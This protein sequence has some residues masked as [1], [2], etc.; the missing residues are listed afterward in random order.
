M[1]LLVLYQARDSIK[2]HPGYHDG[3]CRL[4]AEGA[5]ESHRAIPYYSVSE[6]QGW[7]D[8]WEEA[9]Q[10]ARELPADAVFLQFFHARMPNPSSG[11]LRIKELPLHMDGGTCRR[12]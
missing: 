3:F 12:G 6:K 2:G 11:I 4:V 8:L 7:N 9:Y 1:K 5:L 10:A